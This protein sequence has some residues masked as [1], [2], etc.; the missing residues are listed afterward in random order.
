MP[1]KVSSKKKGSKTAVVNE[2]TGK[3]QGY[4]NNPKAYLKALYANAPEAAK[5]GKKRG[6][7]K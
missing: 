4:S 2:D 7:K 6:K 5:K 1:W 3:V